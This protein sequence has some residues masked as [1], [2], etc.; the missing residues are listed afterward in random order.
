MNVTIDIDNYLLPKHCLDN[1]V[2]DGSGIY[3]TI[4]LKNLVKGSKHRPIFRRLL[5][6]NDSLILDFIA[7]E[8][9]NQMYWEVT[10]SRPQQKQDLTKL[11]VYLPWSSSKII[12]VDSE[13]ISTLIDLR[14][15]ILSEGDEL[16]LYTTEDIVWVTERVSSHFGKTISINIDSIFEIFNEI[17]KA[18]LSLWYSKMEDE[19]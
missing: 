11:L 18:S 1:I 16:E 3:S 7:L 4:E 15:K 2:T 13:F 8:K 17:D 6:G 19:I 5:A 9:I 14:N 12:K 10:D